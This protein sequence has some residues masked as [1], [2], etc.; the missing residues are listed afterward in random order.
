MLKRHL[1]LVLT[2]SLASAWGSQ[3]LLAQESGIKL[4]AEP[5]EVSLVVGT[6]IALVVRAV[7][8][9]GDSVDMDVRVAA[10][11]SVLRYRNGVLQSY[12]AR[13][14]EPVATGVPPD[15]RTVHPPMH[16]TPCPLP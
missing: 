16:L 14:V 13:D 7:D 1:W 2:L 9:S 15:G 5:A 8:E 10:P 12:L 3:R 4:V 11:R 6:Q